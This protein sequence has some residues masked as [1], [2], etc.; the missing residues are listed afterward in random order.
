[1]YSQIR[2]VKWAKSMLVP[3]DTSSKTTANTR[4]SEVNRMEKIIKAENFA[5]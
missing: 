5:W 4:H 3:L 1:M 2:Y